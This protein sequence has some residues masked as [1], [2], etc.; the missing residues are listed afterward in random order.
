M[1]EDPVV[2]EITQV[3]KEVD[4]LEKMLRDIQAEGDG[5]LKVSQLSLLWFICLI[6]GEGIITMSCACIN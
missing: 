2:K 1:E 5:I 6:R 4:K 3:S